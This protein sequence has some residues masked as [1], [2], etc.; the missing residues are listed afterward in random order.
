MEQTVC[1]ETSAYK[2]QM[3]GNYRE[4]NIQHPEHGEGLKSRTENI[5][6]FAWIQT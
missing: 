6:S 1:S 5:L 3:P 2:L 4:E